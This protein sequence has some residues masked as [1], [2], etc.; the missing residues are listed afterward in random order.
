[1]RESESSDGASLRYAQPPDL[2]PSCRPVPRVAVLNTRDQRV[3]EFDGVLLAA[4]SDS[5]LYLVLLLAGSAG[6]RRLIPIGSAW[7]DQTTEVIRVDDADVQSA[8][9]FDLREFERMTPAEVVAFERRVLESCC[10]EVLRDAGPPTYET[11]SQF[12]CPDWLKA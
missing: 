1:M 12:R 8:S 4:T 6:E 2:G 10:P 9:A 5:P 3:G 11:A 7:F